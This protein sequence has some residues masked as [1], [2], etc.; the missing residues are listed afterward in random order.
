[1]LGAAVTEAG[2]ELPEAEGRASRCVRSRAWS[3]VR[4]CATLV[5]QRG[6]CKGEGEGEWPNGMLPKG[7]EVR[8]ESTGEEHGVLWEVGDAGAEGGEV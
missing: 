5:G 7:V 4:S 6:E 1:M 3:S 2:V 8:P